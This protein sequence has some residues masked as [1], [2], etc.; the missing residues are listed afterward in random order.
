MKSAISRFTARLGTKS[1]SLLLPFGLMLFSFAVKGQQSIFVNN[2]TISGTPPQV[3]A[4]NFYNSGSWNIFTSP[5]PYQTAH[6][7][8]YTNTGTMVGSVGWEFDYGPLPS[9]GRGMSANFVNNSASA[10]I[11]ANYRYV[12]NP[13][14]V[15]DYYYPVGYLWV[16][17]TNIVN[18]GTLQADA[19]SEIR[20][21]GTNVNLSRSTVEIAP[22]PGTG[23]FNGTTNFSSDVAVYDEYW[24]QAT[25][26]LDS[27]ATWNGTNA[28]SSSL[29]SVDVAVKC[30]GPNLVVN[31]GYLS[32]APTVADSTNIVV[33]SLLVTFTN[34]DVSGRPIPGSIQIPTNIIH[35][36]VFVVNNDPN[37]AVAIGFTPS[38]NP[39]NFFKTVTVQL[40]NSVSGGALYLVDTLASDPGRGLL[41]NSVIYPFDKCGDPTDRPTNYIVTRIL[42]GLL[43]SPGQGTP[44]ANFLYGTNWGSRIVSGASYAA[45]SFLVYNGLSGQ[46]VSSNPSFTNAPGRIYIYAG[47]LNLNDAQI[48]QPPGPGVQGDGALII[49]ANHLVN[50]Q[51]AT[52]TFR[53]LSFNLGSTNG[54]LNVTNLVSASSL[55]SGLNGTVSEWSAVWT[56][57]YNVVTANSTM[58]VTGSSTN[59]VSSPLTNTVQVGLYALLVDA[60]QLKSSSPV[61]VY[62]LLLH[63]TN[64]VVSDSM[65]VAD[66]FLLDG[67]TFTLLGD[68]TLSGLVQNWTY[69]NAPNLRYFTNNGFLSIPNDAHFGDDTAVPYAEFVNNGIIFSADQTIDS[70]DLQINHGINYTSAGDFSATAGSIEITGPPSYGFSYSIYSG[71]DIDLFANTLLIDPAALLANGALNFTVVSNLSDNGTAD[72]FTCYNGFNLWIKPNTGDLLG[73]TITSIAS[74][75]REEIDHAWAGNDYGRYWAGSNNVVIGTLVL[76]AQNPHPNN[77]LYE[78]LFHF[79]GTTGSNAMYVTTLDLRQLTTNSADVANM[80]QIDPGMKIYVPPSGV[81]LGFTLPGNPPPTPEEFLQAQVPGIYV[82]LSTNAPVSMT[83]DAQPA[84]R[85][86]ISPL[87]YG[88]AFASSNQLADL[89][90]TL[91]RSGG[92][93]ETRYNWQLN[94]HNHASD[95][96]F[97]SIDDGNATPGASADDFVANSKYGGAQAMITIPMIG[98]MPKLGPSRSKLA[99]YSIVKYGPQTGNDSSWMPDAG[100]GISVTNSTPI[101]W[102]NPNDANFPTNVVFQQGYVQHLTNR[103]GL[104]TNGGVRYYIMDNEHSLWFSTHQDVH[105]VG[106]KMGEIL[107]N[108]LTYASMVKSNDPNALVCGPEEWGWN[109]YLYSGYDQQWFNSTKDYN[110]AHYPD[111]TANGGW[112]YCPWLL[113]QFYQ[114]STNHGNRRLL[115][116]F[117]LHC[118]PQENNVS[119]NAVDSATELLRNQSTRTF[120]DTIY[121]NQSWI[122]NVIMLIPRMKIWVATNYPGTKIGITEYNWGAEANINGATAQA[123]ILGIFGREGLD[124]ATRWET[125]AT[126]T[127]TYLAMKLY[128][129]YDGNKSTFGDSSIPMVVPN[130][131]VLSIFGAVR[132]SDG[133]MT[134]MV[135]NKDLRNATPITLNITNNA[136]GTNVQRWQLTSANVINH[137]SPITLANGVLSDV[138]PAQSITLYV[139]SASSGSGSVSLQIGTKN[140]TGQQTLRLNGQAGQTYIIQSSTNL[141]TWQTLY[142]T[143]PPSLPITLVVTNTGDRM[144]F[145]RVKT[146]P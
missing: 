14:G 90:F 137:L 53:N 109:G 40:S 67:Q 91:N 16:S 59:W 73:S 125:P 13:N 83:V 57:Q 136:A 8:N 95:W 71:G 36:A 78:P 144:R 3:D 32:F 127:P 103:W 22:V 24:G 2:G 143:N 31:G 84:N 56:N 115:D 80:I 107:T 54:N 141:V 49:Q 117:T 99:S 47:V 110:P 9:G 51:K 63:S 112:D 93:A 113:N 50:N 97:E 105:P 33:G 23:S 44:P 88:V 130:P 15:W 82:V 11:Q 111:R 139:L 96:Y 62:D 29:P 27:A 81:S 68:L 116:Y 122:N 94:A 45:Y 4:T 37:I 129:N 133:A 69:A 146:G 86:P 10:L 41:P 138:V 43:G 21:V 19:Y 55:S 126:N 140:S 98:W 66:S 5:Y 101:T 114:D 135:I 145:Y 25:T 20:L 46:P 7:L 52:I 42:S 38:A 77:P 17:A 89:N 132:T 124:L 34:L 142:T 119:G 123:D 28:A 75:D 30:G 65:T 39:T 58:V 92:N 87:I 104:S 100:N 48:L 35:Q 120:W 6:T 74:L 64:I 12:Y 128:R 85:K 72:S 102:N 76:S 1:L 108:M 18:K 121:T 118:Y 79:Y 106:P 131:D 60:R 70:L 26:N 61:T 134:F